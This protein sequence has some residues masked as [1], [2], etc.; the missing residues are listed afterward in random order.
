[1]ILKAESFK[2]QIYIFTDQLQLTVQ[3]PQVRERRAQQNSSKSKY[4]FVCGQAFV[5]RKQQD[6]MGGK[7]LG[8]FVTL[9]FV[10]FFNSQITE[11]V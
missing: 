9:N 6:K 3:S 1:M 10:L 2:W 7:L 5:V 11:N 4:E 8:H